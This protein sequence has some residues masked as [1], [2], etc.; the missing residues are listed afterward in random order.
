MVKKLKYK[1]G[2]I[3]CIVGSILIILSQLRL[4][5]VILPGMP[6]IGLL[7]LLIGI[8]IIYPKAKKIDEYRR[9]RKQ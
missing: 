9:S 6:L 2:F 5:K 4:I 7:I 3:L 1:T 8:I